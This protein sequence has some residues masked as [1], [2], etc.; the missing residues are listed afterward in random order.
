MAKRKIGCLLVGAAMSCAPSSQ[1]ASAPPAL[2]TLSSFRELRPHLGVG[3]SLVRV[4]HGFRRKG[5]SLV[6]YLPARA[7]EPVR[8]EDPSTP[9]VY[10]EIEDAHASAI[11]GRVREGAVVYPNVAL[12]T[13]LVQVAEPARIEELRL[14]RS[15]RAPTTTHYKLRR[16]PAIAEVRLRGHRVEVIDRAG[17]V[18]FAS[19]EPFAIDSKGVRRELSLTL[20]NDTLDVMLDTTGLSFPVAVDPAWTA[21]TSME[22]R[23]RAHRAVRLASGKVLVAGGDFLSSAELY[24][25]GLNTWSAAGTMSATRREFTLTVLASGKVLAAGAMADSGFSVSSADLYDPASNTWSAAAPMTSARQ[26]HQ[27]TLLSTGKVLVT[28][29]N[30]PGG[31]STPSITVQTAELYDSVTNTWSPAGFMSVGRTRHTATLLAS[32]KVLLAGGETG[33]SGSSPPT[34]LSTAELYDPSSNTWSNAKEMKNTRSAHTAS[35]LN[36]GRVLVAAGSWPWTTTSEIYDATTNTWVSTKPLVTARDRHA[37]AVLPSGKVVV[38]GGLAGGAGSELASTEVFDPV[39]GEWS[40]GGLL[41][42]ARIDPTAT[43]LTTGAIL[44]TGGG[45]DSSYYSSAEVFVP[46]ALGKGCAG[47]GECS[48]GFCVDGV[49]CATTCVGQCQAC[50]LPSS[51]GTCTTVNPT[52]GPAGYPAGQSVTGFGTTIRKSCPSYGATCGSRCDGTSA[53]ECIFDVISPACIPDTGAPDTGAPDTFVPDGFAPDTFVPDTFV[54]DG[55]VPDTFV[56]D[57]FI[58]DGLAPAD[59]SAGDGAKMLATDAATDDAVPLDDTMSPPDSNPP[60]TLEAPAPFREVALADSGGCGCQTAG[61]GASP[62]GISALGLLAVLFL[63]RR[64]A[65]LGFAL[66]A[67]CSSRIVEYRVVD[68]TDA[69]PIDSGRVVGGACTPAGE[70]AC[71]G[72]GQKQQLLCDG[73]A[74]IANGVCS[75]DQVCDPRPGPT[76]GSCQSPVCGSGPNVCQGSVLVTCAADGLSVKREECA[77][78]EHCR[79]A[80]GGICARCLSWSARCE[81]PTLFR[82]SP[83][84]QELVFKET[85]GSPALCDA[86]GG[87]CK[88]PIC[89]PGAVRCS[90]DRLETCSESGLEYELTTVCDPGQCDAPTKKCRMVERCATGEYR[91]NGDVLEQCNLTRTAFEPDRVCLPGFCDSAN[92]ECD[93]CKSGSA[94]CAGTTPRACDS[95]GHWKTLT[96]CS[97]TTP[98]CSG[99]ACIAAAT[100]GTVFPTTSAIAWNEF[101]GTTTLGAGGGMVHWKTG[102]YL[103]DKLARSTPVTKIDFNFKMFDGTSS[104]TCTIG[105]LYWAV[106]LNG[107]DVGKFSWTGGSGGTKLVVESFT[108][109]PIAPIDGVVKVHIEATTSVCSGGGSWNWYSGGTA[110]MY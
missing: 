52:N 29:G 12:D 41:T 110:T 35:L 16:G 59:T 34:Y 66:L 101:G 96:A 2:S 105:T 97:G 72:V 61:G 103:E 44:V 60:E 102:S 11:D 20:T 75:G 92:R 98:V 37:A 50:N 43:L 80:V 95:T 13:D 22:S 4:A 104:T 47:N 64:T 107:V 17:A 79:Q 8:L 28:G 45:K 100:M 10:L 15:N 82:C 54:P 91:C 69:G 57:A 32:G 63:R 55:F 42:V 26:Y 58:P 30:A 24:D 106:R 27:A 33:A 53:S 84:R 46:L 108:F 36:D 90:G 77:T 56:A 31:V 74:W 76:L 83:D 62:F 19:E 94:E 5:A 18:R 70:L 23:R 25:P 49:C 71:Q 85:C 51:L 9:G 7:S 1:E 68:S 14:L 78:T 73:T 99:G 65:A 6:A 87:V 39:L 88:I 3:G 67:G 93:E 109:A 40:S 38:V 86:T 89:T 48:S 81:G 21:V